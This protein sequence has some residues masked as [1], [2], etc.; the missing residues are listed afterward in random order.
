[1]IVR[2]DRLVTVEY[3]VNATDGTQT[4]TWTPLVYAVGSPAVA[5]KFPAEVQDMLS[6]IQRIENVLLGLAL[7]RNQVRVRMRWRGDITSAMRI[8]VHG[9]ADRV[10]QIIG[11]P[12]EIGGRKQFIEVF[13]ESISS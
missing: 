3:P 12:A 7:A 2:L 8:T 11:G 6:S 9:E 10:L 13:C 5:E 1:M 4:P